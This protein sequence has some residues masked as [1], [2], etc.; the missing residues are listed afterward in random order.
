MPG[1]GSDRAWWRPPAWSRSPLL[2]EWIRSGSILIAAAW[3]VYT[4]VWQDI[5][6]PSWQPAHLSLEASLAP[7]ADRPASPDGLEMSL[8]FKASNASSRRVYPLASVWSL[9]EINREA[10]AGG[11]APPDETLFFREADQAL[12][13]EA[14]S[15]AERGVSSAP[16][17]LL[18]LGRLLDDDF[19]DP[20]ES[21]QRTLLVRMPPGASAAELQVTLLLL[22]R[23]PAGLFQ[24]GRLN[25]G[26]SDSGDPL[27]LICAAPP[28]DA[29]G[30]SARCRPYDEASER[31]LQQFDPKKST[32][33]LSQQIGLPL[34]LPLSSLRVDHAAAQDAASPQTP[35][36]PPAAEARA[37]EQRP[38]GRSPGS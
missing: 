7:V 20:G 35:S 25:W 26:L 36:A 8:Q 21:V 13:G 6:V 10:R 28:A 32:I 16:G 22:T 14:L 5:L 17:R 27:P 37:A 33:T 11:S 29:R 31:E 24:G 34:S 9:R 3:G 19:L 18:A 2:H 38:R 15:H 4:F 30:G 12:R 1:S 23:R